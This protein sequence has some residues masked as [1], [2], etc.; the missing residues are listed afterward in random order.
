M[1]TNFFFSNFSGAAGT[2]Q[3]NSGIS[4]QKSLISLVSR[5]MPNF[6][7]PTPS[8]GRPP[9]QW[10]I[11][12]PTS[13][14]LCSFF[15]PD[16]SSSNHFPQVSNLENAFGDEG[17]GVKMPPIHRNPSRNV[18][19]PFRAA[20]PPPA[21]PLLIVGTVLRTARTGGDWQ[22]LMFCPLSPSPFLGHTPQYGWDFPEEI[23][24][25]P[26]KRSQSVSWNSPREYGWDA[27]N[28]IIQ[29]I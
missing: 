13:V 14:G 17:Q 7:A 4:R 21:Q 24:E 16:L 12:G 5:D 22:G 9:P 6:W 8:R 23:P 18:W 28:A 27:P 26:R 15:L 2:S 29:G 20:T 3:Q 25:R 19:T 11:S 10:K 1:N